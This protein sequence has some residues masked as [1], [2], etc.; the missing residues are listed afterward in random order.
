[1]QGSVGLYIA[2]LF[3]MLYTNK[4]PE[5]FS[6]G[7]TYRRDYLLGKYGSP[8]QLAE[9]LVVQ[10]TFSYNTYFFLSVYL[11]DLFVVSVWA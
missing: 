10:N 11:F 1:M 6:W 8:L 5:M 3:I 4:F 2:E 7:S 9:D